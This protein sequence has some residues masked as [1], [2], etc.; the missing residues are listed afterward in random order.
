MTD[1]GFGATLAA[2]E[3]LAARAATVFLPRTP[4]TTRDLFAGRWGELTEISD[5]VHQP[6][7]HV[8]IYGERGVGKSS[9]ANVISPTVRALDNVG[10]KEE[11]LSNRLVLKAVANSGDTFSTIWRRLIGDL[12]WPEEGNETQLLSTDEAY[13][14][15]SSIGIDDVRRVLSHTG[16]GVFIVDEFDQ[17]RRDISK[18]FT[19]L[20]KALSDLQTDCTIVLVGVSQ[21]VENLLDDHASINRAIAQ[22]R[23]E[24]MKADELRQILEK[25]EK[26]LS[27]RFDEDAAKLIV[28]VSQ[29]L[30]HYTHL[31]GLHA[32]RS[33]AARLSLSKVTCDD[34]FEALKKA[35]KQAEQ[36]VTQNHSTAV[37]SSQKKALYRHVLLACALAATSTHD[38]LGYFTPSSVTAPLGQILQRPI[39]IANFTN[40]LGEFCDEKRASVLERDGQPWGYRYRFRDP[41]LVP[42]VFMDGVEAGILS[43][44]GLVQMLSRDDLF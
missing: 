34:V 20:I 2:S 42:F 24:R 23:L 16:G 38:A 25:A 33:A 14:L 11:P 6:G 35:I 13:G 10:N 19:E 36:T 5:A 15:T 41:L 9:L 29:G 7:L 44:Q 17:A 4:V 21:T 8:V 39:T 43:G 1:Q 32:V 40:H 3:A 22:I 37:H 30:P 31:L 12:R 26:A 27:I 28:H 18:G